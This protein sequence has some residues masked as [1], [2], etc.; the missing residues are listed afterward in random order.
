MCK[1][2]LPNR[3][4]RQQQPRGRGRGFLPSGLHSNVG[5]LDLR[6]KSLLHALKEATAYPAS[7]ADPKTLIL[8]AQANLLSILQFGIGQASPSHQVVRGPQAEARCQ[9][10][11]LPQTTGEPQLPLGVSRLRGWGLGSREVREGSSSGW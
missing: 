7:F 3:P 11:S 2:E 1:A 5:E 9:L 8:A 6:G 4:C 10:L